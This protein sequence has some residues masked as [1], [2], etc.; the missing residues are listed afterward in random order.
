M[1][2]LFS[3]NATSILQNAISSSDT[4]LTLSTGTGSLFPSIGGSDYFYLTLF[5]VVGSVEINHEIIKVTNKVSDVLTV[6]R[7]QEGTTAR[8]WAA[9][10]KIELRITAGA[11]DTIKTNITNLN[12]DKIS[13]SLYVTDF[14][15]ATDQTSNFVAA[16]A[17]A[18]LAGKSLFHPGG[19]VKI[20]KATVR[21]PLVGSQTNTFG[22]LSNT[23]KILCTATDGTYGLW[24][25]L[26]D[27]TLYMENINCI[28]NT[29]QGTYQNLTGIKIGSYGSSPVTSYAN[30]RGFVSN[31]KVKG[32]ST[33]Y[34]LQGW[35]NRYDNLWATYCSIG[36]KIEEAHGSSIDFIGEYNQKDIQCINSFGLLFPRLEMEGEAGTTASTFDGCLG[37]IINCIYAEQSARTIPWLIVGGTTLCQDFRILGG[38]FGSAAGTQFIKL[39][40]VIGHTI[41]CFFNG[42][43]VATAGTSHNFIETTANTKG[44]LSNFPAL[45][46]AFPNSLLIDGNKN[47]CS[48]LFPNPN[49]QGQ[50]FGV[51]DFLI[52]GGNRATV[53]LDT[54]NFRTGTNSLKITPITGL[55]QNSY[56]TFDFRN[57]DVVNSVKSKPLTLGVWLY[58]PNTTSMAEGTSGGRFP[59]IQLQTWLGG[60]KLDDVSTT[61][62]R[63]RIGA[64]NFLYITIP[65][66][67]ATLDRIYVNIAPVI[68]SATAVGD[69][70]VLVDSIYLSN[71]YHAV[72]MYEGRIIN[73]PLNPVVMS[74]GKIT[75][76]APQ[77]Y[78][79]LGDNQQVWQVGDKFLYT[80]PA[81]AG[82][83]GKICTTGGAGSSSVWKTF[84]AI[85]A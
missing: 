68:S 73:S 72:N 77:S 47:Q 54:T 20:T 4:S 69:E 28:S 46:G 49:L 83:M 56:V 15:G 1:A 53:S 6:V 3:N 14:T 16:E 33:G 59:A 79:G 44:D 64:W 70:Y 18:Y 74:A 23:P 31:V 2:Q 22:T 40:N 43:Y 67:N 27:G 36:A 55:N 58:V 25:P 52:A 7:G 80:D 17:A 60:T 9:S 63:C 32:F 75:L 78:G 30:R 82:F 39:D 29:A 10:T 76:S 42:N 38:N 21:V 8:A 66:V 5:S 12:S 24:F 65:S 81:A 13:L 35:L 62:G 85:S 34:E 48:N 57:V 50:R 51:D 37:L 41:N 11:L 19:I 84:G 26:A 61:A 71:E 45:S